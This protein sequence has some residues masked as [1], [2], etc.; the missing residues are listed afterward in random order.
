M[1]AKEEKNITVHMP[2]TFVLL[3]PSYHIESAIANSPFFRYTI[4]KTTKENTHG[5][6][7]RH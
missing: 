4:R 3:H 2:T 7:R 6:I 1:L 5:K